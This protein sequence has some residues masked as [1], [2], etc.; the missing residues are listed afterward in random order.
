VKSLPLSEF[1]SFCNSFTDPLITSTCW[2]EISRGAI[3]EYKDNWVSILGFCDTAPLLQS[4]QKCK[5]RVVESLVVSKN[6]DIMPLKELCLA[7]NSNQE[8]ENN[9]YSRLIRGKMDNDI[10]I[11][12]DKAVEFCLSLERQFQKSCF[13]QI[14]ASFK[15][16]K[17]HSKTVDIVCR[18]A[19]AEYQNTCRGVR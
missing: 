9:C 18:S 16:R 6:F 14:G 1:S 7:S 11:E 8:F 10:V 5:D 4:R 3:A 2:G 17:V 15:D 19:P 12:N 13:R